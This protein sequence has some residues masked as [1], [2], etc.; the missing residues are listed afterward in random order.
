MVISRRREVLL[1]ED[2]EGDIRLMREAFR[3]V[4]APVGLSI[5]TDGEQAIERLKTVRAGHVIDLV[6]LDLNLPKLDGREVLRKMKGD[7]F[8]AR[9]P[10]V[11]LTTSDAPQD[12]DTAYR[13]HANCYFTKPKDIAE[14][15]ELVQLIDRFWL[16]GA[17]L[18][19][20]V[21]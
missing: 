7:P 13:L 8:L 15:F 17:K 5:V 3:D 20:M 11:V 12:V 16:R 1:V 9:I 18:A 10:V 19:T 21:A 6:L 4:T 14:L 2:S